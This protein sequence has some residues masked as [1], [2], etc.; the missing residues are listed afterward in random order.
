M[1]FLKLKK[2]LVATRLYWKA[3]HIQKYFSSR[4]FKDYV[5]SNS[6][7]EFFSTTAFFFFLLFQRTT[8]ANITS[9]SA[10]FQNLS[11]EEA[12]RK[13][14]ALYDSVSRNLAGSACCILS[15]VSAK[16]P[17]SFSFSYSFGPIDNFMRH[18][19]G[20]WNGGEFYRSKRSANPKGSKKI[21]PPRSKSR[22]QPKGRKN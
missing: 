4:K 7:F 13:T 11:E 19:S 1:Q 12:E 2:L 15:E 8:F 5:L 20:G 14:R 3:N 21:L 9:N 18:F 16:N 17:S 10:I 6:S 22:T